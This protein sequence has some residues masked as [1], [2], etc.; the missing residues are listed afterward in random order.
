MARTVNLRE[1]LQRRGMARDAAGLAKFHQDA[2]VNLGET[3]DE[4]EYAQ[5]QA[6]YDA[7]N[8]RFDDL[9]AQMS[10]PAATEYGK[11]PFSPDVQRRVRRLS[12]ELKA[13]RGRLDDCRAD[14]RRT[15]K[16]RK[17]NE[18]AV[19]LQQ[20]AAIQQEVAGL[21][22]AIQ[23]ERGI[24]SG[25][26]IVFEMAPDVAADLAKVPG[27]SEYPEQD[28]HMAVPEYAGEELKQSG[29][30]DIAAEGKYEATEWEVEDRK[31]LVEDLQRRGLLARGK[32]PDKGELREAVVGVVEGEAE[33]LTT[34]RI[35]FRGESKGSL[36][37]DWDTL[38]PGDI[39][40]MPAM[41]FTSADPT[42]A[43]YFSARKEATSPGS[44][45]FVVVEHNRGDPAIVVNSQEQEIN[46]PQGAKLEFISQTKEPFAIAPQKD[47]EGNISPRRFR[48]NP[49]VQDYDKDRDKVVLGPTA[50]NIVRV[51]RVKEPAGGK[52]KV[53]VKA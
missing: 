11:R 40:E 37:A 18:A 3:V 23:V 51:R 24:R 36:S 2:A 27:A 12:R 14:S 22:Y 21:S 32:T 44:G 4:A 19:V 31:A 38:K 25:R 8:R 48:W 17:S 33:S 43:G 52:V 7:A 35:T 29:M 30:L 39:I 5:A 1:E 47:A 41:A 28:L 16:K 26:P 49:E 15:A 20:C 6:A 34:P 13:A 9:W 46:I 50:H 42:H 53:N 10:D 45:V